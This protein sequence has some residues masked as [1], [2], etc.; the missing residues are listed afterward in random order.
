MK[1]YAV[2]R[3]RNFFDI[4]NKEFESFFA[5]TFPEDEMFNWKP[6]SRVKEEDNYYH[7]VMDIPG[8]DKENLKV[9]LKDNVMSIAGERKDH[10]ADE[11]SEADTYARFEQKFSLPKDV[12]MD[13]IDVHQK[14]GVLEVVLPKARKDDQHKTLHIK[15]G[16]SAYLKA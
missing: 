14:D 3:P 4:F 5:P 1:N 8:V 6:L 16:R 2:T 10:F 13:E 7:L 9:E 12:N 15:E 11:K